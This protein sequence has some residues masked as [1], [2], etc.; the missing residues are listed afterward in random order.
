MAQILLATDFSPVAQNAASYAAHLARY[1]QMDLVLFH[2]YIIPFAY[3][4]SAVPLL[5]TEEVRAISEASMDAE[6]IRLKAL[7][8]SLSII[9]RIVPGD[10][11]DCIHEEIQENSPVLIVLGTSGDKEDSVLWGSMAVKA[12]RAFTVPVLTVPSKAAW[13]PLSKMCFAADY[14][15]ITENTPFHEISKW[16]KLMNAGFS[17]V[18]IDTPPAQT[19]EPPALLRSSLANLDPT[20]HSVS[21]DRIEEGVQA[22]INHHQ[23]DWLIL[24]PRKYGFWKS[25]FHKSRTKM[26]AQVSHIPILS[27]HQKG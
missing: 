19:T 5:N 24:I 20:Y 8:P 3:A 7:E 26:L 17:V 25:L 22:F 10:L 23:I 18:H 12:L 11:I 15:T 21:T 2:A 4:D 6:N 27:L 13:E 14:H 1:L 16:V 9:S